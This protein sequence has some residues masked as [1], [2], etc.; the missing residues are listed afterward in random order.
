MNWITENKRKIR[1]F[2]KIS[3]VFVPFLIWSFFFET[4]FFILRLLEK[5]DKWGTKIV[6]DWIEKDRSEN[7][8]IL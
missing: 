2:L 6:T 7:G 5:F 3:M 8:N 4:I 1:L